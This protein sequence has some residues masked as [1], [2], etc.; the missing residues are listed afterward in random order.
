MDMI[1]IYAAQFQVKSCALGNLCKNTFESHLYL[2]VK[3]TPTSLRHK[4]EV[5]SKCRAAVGVAQGLHVVE[6]MHICKISG[7]EA[8][9]FVERSH[10]QTKVRGFPAI[11]C[12]QP[13]IQPFIRDVIIQTCEKVDIDIVQTAA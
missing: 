8:D 13:D 7:H 10:P 6:I 12:K 1:S 3:D 9:D 5:I 4:D 2:A 11:V